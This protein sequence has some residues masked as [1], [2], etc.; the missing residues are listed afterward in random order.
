MMEKDGQGDSTCNDSSSSSSPDRWHVSPPPLKRRSNS[1]AEQVVFAAAAAGG[2]QKRSWLLGLGSTSSSLPASSRAPSI[3]M[4]FIG[5]TSDVLEMT[6]GR[7]PATRSAAGTAARG[8]Y[9]VSPL[10]KLHSDGFLVPDGPHHTH[11]L[12]PH[13]PATDGSTIRKSISSASQQQR[14]HPQ[15]QG[16]PPWPSAVHDA[17]ELLR[18]CLNA[19]H[20]GALEASQSTQWH[21]RAAFVCFALAAALTYAC[22]VGGAT[23]PALAAGSM[24]AA[25]WGGCVALAVVSILRISRFPLLVVVLVACGGAAVASSLLVLYRVGALALLVAAG[26]A[27]FPLGLLLLWIACFETEKDVRG[28]V[29]TAAALVV[30][31]QRPRYLA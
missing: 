19:V 7:V 22:F 29:R 25:F 8:D 1:N 20:E 17:D 10:D 9:H 30:L 13:H 31:L 18:E 15:A 4:P 2:V 3:T 23:A 28:Y 24:D 6:R 14:A 16:R 5:T 12:A 27:L 11:N 26:T 21:L